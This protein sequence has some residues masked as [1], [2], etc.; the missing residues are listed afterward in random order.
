MK[1]EK[2]DERFPRKRFAV[3]KKKKAPTG[4]EETFPM[5]RFAKNR[6]RL[7]PSMERLFLEEYRR[8]EQEVDFER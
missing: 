5:K 1:K 8:E 3:M 2:Q 4:D 7:Q 6:R